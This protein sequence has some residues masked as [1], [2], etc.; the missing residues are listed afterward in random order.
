MKLKGT[1]RNNQADT[2][3]SNIRIA[4]EPISGLLI[5]LNLITL[6]TQ[7]AIQTVVFTRNCKKL[8]MKFI[9]FF[10]LI[11]LLCQPSFVDP[12]CFRY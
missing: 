6:P 12:D 1:T 3:K 4:E 11:H 10:I 5:I 2:R 8:I 9:H 7:Y